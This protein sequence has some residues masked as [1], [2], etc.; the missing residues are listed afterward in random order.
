MHKTFFFIKLNA[1]VLEDDNHCGSVMLRKW[2]DQYSW[3]TL[4][5]KGMDGPLKFW[6][7]AAYTGH[8]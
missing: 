5:W 8:L 6:N 1:L 4:S 7:F 3:Q 2:N